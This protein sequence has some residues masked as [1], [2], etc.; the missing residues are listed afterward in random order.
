MPKPFPEPTASDNTYARHDEGTVSWLERSTVQE[1]VDYRDFLN[2]NLSMLPGDCEKGIYEH[3]CNEQHHK[4]GLLELIVGRTLQE[5]GASIECEPEGLPSGKRPDFVAKFPDGTVYVEAVSP[6]LD[7]ELEAIA[8][9]ET[10]ITKL[11]EDHVPPG[12]A[13]D[14]RALPRVGPDE[15]KRHIKA[16]LKK[17]MDIPSPTHD[18]DEVEVRQTFGQGD[19]RI[20]L[21]PQSRHGL[22]KD[23]KIAIYNGIG[24]SP[25]DQKVL[26]SAVKRKYEQLSKLDEP[27]LVA[28]NM[29]STT[30]TREDSRPSAARRNGKPERSARQRVGTVL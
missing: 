6:R 17:E 20:V 21:F 25:N 12:W 19:L 28:L 18:N 7:R 15:S 29:H 27:T 4:D 26:R 22:D 30:S 2:R 8:G 9:S 16:F 10:P 14:I 24:Y 23:V 5:M 13:A 11:V 3:L 1:A